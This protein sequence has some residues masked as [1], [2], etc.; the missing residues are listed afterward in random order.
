MTSLILNPL[1][2]MASSATDL[3]SLRNACQILLPLPSHCL[4]FPTG[5]GDV[6]SVHL[7]SPIA[8]PSC[9]YG[10]RLG[11]SDSRLLSTV[12]LCVGE[13]L[14]SDSRLTR[15]IYPQ[16]RDL[17]KVLLHRKSTRKGP[18]SN[19]RPGML[20]EAAPTIRVEGIRSGCCDSLCFFFST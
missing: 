15:I 6:S 1:T 10:I 5:H 3:G 7:I 12:M 13:L 20:R 11:C 9:G 14:L 4:L 18:R 8:A 17:A 19:S 2:L 16:T